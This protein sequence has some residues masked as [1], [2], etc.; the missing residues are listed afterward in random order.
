MG[1]KDGLM[2]FPLMKNNFDARSVEYRQYRPG[3]PE[4]LCDYMMGRCGL[5]RGSRVLDVGAGTGKASAPL[6]DRGI[7]TLS[8]EQSLAMIQQGLKAYPTF[9]YVR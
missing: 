8:V 7:R 2:F 5:H 3:Y 9:Q 1:S 6:V 4:E